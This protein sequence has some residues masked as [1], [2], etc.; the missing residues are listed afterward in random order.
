[1]QLADLLSLALH[2]DRALVYRG[3]RGVPN[4]L[5]MEGAC[6]ILTPPNSGF[7]FLSAAP[8]LQSNLSAPLLPHTPSRR[9]RYLGRGER[10]RE[11]TL[12][13]PKSGIP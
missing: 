6:P 11:A 8:Q 10:P 3:Q 1:M 2:T 7:C 13:G 9:E 12:T 5:L 4:F